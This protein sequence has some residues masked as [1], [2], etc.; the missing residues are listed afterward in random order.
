VI[1]LD[2]LG[3]P[4]PQARPRVYQVAGHARA[5][6]E[7]TGWYWRVHLA[8]LQARDAGAECL[9][10]PVALTMAHRMPR[11]KSLPKRKP[12][13]AHVARP[14]WDNLGKVSDALVGVL[15]ARDEQVVDGRVTKRYCEPDEMPGCMITLEALA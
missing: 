1:T 2:V 8:A 13:P 15:L 6:S 4:R 10:G 14:D 3:T 5:V 7:K 11:P 9:Q 12:T